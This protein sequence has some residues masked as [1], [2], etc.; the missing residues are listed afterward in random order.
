MRK[1]AVLIGMVGGVFLGYVLASV[2]RPQQVEARAW[3][4]G[5]SVPKTAGTLKTARARL[6]VLRGQRRGGPGRRHCLQAQA[7]S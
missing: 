2:V 3:P 5:C 6:A 4:T 7:H 1:N